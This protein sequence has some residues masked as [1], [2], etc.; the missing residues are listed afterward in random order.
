[1]GLLTYSCADKACDASDS[2]P[3]G[4]LDS[5]RRKILTVDTISI[6]QKM[7]VTLF[8]NQ[9]HSEKQ[10]I[11]FHRHPDVAPL[12]VVPLEYTCLQSP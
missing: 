6:Y 7:S 2:L 9:L 8:E 11:L 1:M 5:D 12:T 10:L 3:V 4:M